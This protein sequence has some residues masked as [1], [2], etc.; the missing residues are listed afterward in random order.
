RNPSGISGSRLVAAVST[1]QTSRGRM[2]GGVSQR[3]RQLGSLRPGGKAGRPGSQVPA[4]AFQPY[5]D[6]RAHHR[7]QARHGRYGRRV[8][9]E[10]G[11]GAAL[12]SGAVDD[13]DF[14]VA[15]VTTSRTR[16]GIY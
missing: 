5:E 14:D 3:R 15:A 4:L 6:R 2:A 11:P 10:Q 12:L 9:L 1:E 13:S 7:L 8:V 16:T